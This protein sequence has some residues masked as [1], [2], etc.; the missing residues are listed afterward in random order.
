MKCKVC[1]SILIGRKDKTYCSIECKN[2]YHL[3]LRAV[4]KKTACQLDN[5]LHRN[6]SILSEV[7]GP[8]LKKKQILKSELI[9]KNF[10]FTFH[11][12]S[13]VNSNGKR[14]FHIYD[15]AWM[16]FSDDMVLIVRNKS[17]WIPNKK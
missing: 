15:F 10:Q 6:R 2:D 5:R 7:L 9:K 11:T 16:E 14:Y 1:E 12:H 8:K 4:T 3:T 13:S 17:Q